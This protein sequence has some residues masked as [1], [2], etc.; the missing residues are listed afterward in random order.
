MKINNYAEKE[1]KMKQS[2]LLFIIILGALVFVIGFG[3]GAILTRP[4]RDIAKQQRADYQK[5]IQELDDR[6]VAS[7]EQQINDTTKLHQEL[8]AKIEILINEKNQL[9]SKFHTLQNNTQ[10]KIKKFTSENSQLKSKLRTL[11]NNIIKLQDKQNSII[12]S[13]HITTKDIEQK[14]TE[15]DWVKLGFPKFIDFMHPHRKSEIPKLRI[16]SVGNYGILDY[17]KIFEVLGPY[18]MLIETHWTDQIIRIKGFPT[19][20]LVDGQVWRNYLGRE[21]IIAII[22]TWTYLTAR[23]SQKTIFTAIP[24]DFI[25][26]GLTRTQFEELRK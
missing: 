25:R 10:A 9:K 3:S 12:K 7:R 23:G 20:G 19:K 14:M 2:S 24:F 18:E 4:D 17:P 16:L 11:Q 13:K 21:D 6:Y 22:G 15:T 26:K 1:L 5:K 8:V